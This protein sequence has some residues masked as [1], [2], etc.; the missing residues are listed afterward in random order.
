MTTQ[1]MPRGPLVLLGSLAALLLAAGALPWLAGGSAAARAFAA[2]LLL[3]GAFAGYATLRARAVGGQPSG[4]PGAGPR[5]TADGRSP[6]AIG[7][8]G[9]CACGAGGCQGAQ[10]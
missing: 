4:R 10:Q 8:C 1:P 2:P 6:G 9:G 7:G 5:A 3:A